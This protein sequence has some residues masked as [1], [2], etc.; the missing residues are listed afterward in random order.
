MVRGNREDV[1]ATIE[2]AEDCQLL[3]LNKR[4]DPCK[5]CFINI[6]FAPS[7]YLVGSDFYRVCVM[8]NISNSAEDDEAV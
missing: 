2:M 4:D 5:P 8:F 3:W 1:T 7:F 6:C